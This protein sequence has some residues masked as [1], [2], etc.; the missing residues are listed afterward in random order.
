MDNSAAPGDSLAYKVILTSFGQRAT[1]A[2]FT[3]HTTATGW[4]VRPVRQATTTLTTNFLLANTTGWSTAT[5]RLYAWGTNGTVV[6]KDSTLIATWTVNR[7][8][9]PPPSGGIDSSG[10]IALRELLLDSTMSLV[11]SAELHVTSIGEICNIEWWGNS[12]GTRVVPALGS[13]ST[14]LNVIQTDERTLQTLNLDSLPPYGKTGPYDNP[15][16]AELPRTLMDTRMPQISL[17]PDTVVAYGGQLLTIA[18][19]RASHPNEWPS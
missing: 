16:G 2:L 9:G 5:F 7:S 19:W 14:C 18:Q 6:S 4:N 11:Q 1:G 8:V 12:K 15:S 3:V 17:G 10:A 13:T